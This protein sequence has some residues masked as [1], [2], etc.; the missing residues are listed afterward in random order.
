M[1]KNLF[2]LEQFKAIAAISTS[3][4]IL[5]IAPIF[6]KFV[7]LELSSSATIFNRL[8]GAAIIFGLWRSFFQIRKQQENSFSSEEITK[9]DY[10]LLF[11]AGFFFW[12]SQTSWAWSLTRTSAAISDLLHSVTPIFV[13]LGSWFIYKQKFRHQFIWGTVLALVGSF[14]IGIEHFHS[15][16]YQLQG[17][18]AAFLS[19]ILPVVYVLASERLCCKFSTVTIMFWICTIGTLFSIPVL[20]IT[21]I[22][23]FPLSL[24]GW[25]FTIFLMLAMVLGQGLFLYGIK[26]VGASLMSVL[27]LLCPVLTAIAAWLVFSEILTHLDWGATVIILIGVYLAITSKLYSSLTEF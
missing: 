23:W 1:Q 16:L 18:I 3:L 8:W 13:I 12:A 2:D 25:I 4:L 26:Q 6:I 20:V 27:L 11:F 9:T 15:S 19:S 10:L 24:S 7:E 17:D 21:G 14:M 22:Q 5:G